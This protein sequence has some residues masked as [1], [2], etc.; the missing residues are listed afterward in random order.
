MCFTELTNIRL[1]PQRDCRQG[2][3]IS[4]YLFLLCAEIL[5]IIIWNNKDIK[6]LKIGYVEY[7]LSQYVDDASL[8]QMVLPLRLMV[9]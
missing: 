5:G 7:K 9:F 6:D 2:D 8:F 1:H 4:Y 3:P